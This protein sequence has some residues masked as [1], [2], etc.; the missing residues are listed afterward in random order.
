MKYYDNLFA[1][2]NKYTF[3][4]YF[5]PKYFSKIQLHMVKHGETGAEKLNCSIENHMASEWQ[6][7]N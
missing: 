3:I 1:H 2:T 7:K 4:S 6:T 5:I